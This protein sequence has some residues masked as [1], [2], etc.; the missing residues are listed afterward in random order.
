MGQTAEDQHE[1]DDAEAASPDLLA[2]AV[3]LEP[4]QVAK[5]G[6]GY[7]VGIA[8]KQTG[9][10]CHGPLQEQTLIGE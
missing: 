4:D 9:E 7:V 3:E 2:A 1:T 8:A 5:G 6:D 10:A